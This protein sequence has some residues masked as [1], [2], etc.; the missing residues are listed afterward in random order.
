MQTRRPSLSHFTVNHKFLEQYG[1]AKLLP[2]PG[3]AV[4]VFGDKKNDHGLY[5]VVLDNKTAEIYSGE[6]GCGSA[7]GTTCEQMKPTLEFFA[8]N[9]DDSLHTLTIE[10]LA[11]VN[12]SFFGDIVVT[13]P[14][15][16]AP[17]QLDGTTTTYGSTSSPSAS[18]SANTTKA[19]SATGLLPSSNLFLLLLLCLAVMFRSSSRRW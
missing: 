18:S 16:Y 5:S 2:C 6:S 14:S 1:Q 12:N 15:V 13:V 4:Y 8:S 17:R 19:N 7:F 10:N 9:L 3:G 11:G